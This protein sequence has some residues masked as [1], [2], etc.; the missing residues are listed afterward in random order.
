MALPRLSNL[1]MQIMEVLWRRG[2][3]S[4]RE[5]LEQ[6]PNKKRPAYTTIKTMVVRLERKNA[7]RRIHKALT[8]HVFEATVPREAARRRL[9]ENFFAIFGGEPKSI[10][11]HLVKARKLTLGDIQE[12]EN[13]LR[14]LKRRDKKS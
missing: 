1:E 5:I 14:E 3:S 12:A 6:F 13:Y 2:P 8:G 7:L 9:M 4:V 11:M 10:M